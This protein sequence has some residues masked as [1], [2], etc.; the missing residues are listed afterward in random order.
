MEGKNYSLEVA[1]P[2]LPTI[3]SGVDKIPPFVPIEDFTYTLDSA[4]GRQF[5]DI[6]FT[7]QD[8]PE[9]ENLYYYEVLGGFK[10]DSIQLDT[11]LSVKGGYV[12]DNFPRLT[13]ATG[14]FLLEGR[15]RTDGKL[16]RLTYPDFLLLKLYTYSANYSTYYKSVDDYDEE[17]GGFFPGNPVI[18]TNIE[19]GYGVVGSYAVDSVVVEF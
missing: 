3:R 8:K 17:I 16:I 5:M 12:D 13:T 18:W 11:L 6:Q 9:T 10:L 1:A 14:A 4:F 7:V 19:N 15:L 2:G